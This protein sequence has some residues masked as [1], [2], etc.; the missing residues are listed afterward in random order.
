MTCC[1]CFR[2]VL[3]RKLCCCDHELANVHW[4]TAPEFPPS[5]SFALTPR[6]PPSIPQSILDESDDD[7]STPLP[8]GTSNVV[9]DVGKVLAYDSGLGGSTR[10]HP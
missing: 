8:T 7:D 2:T 5:V 4:T 10:P 9:I 3:P 1:R 6:P